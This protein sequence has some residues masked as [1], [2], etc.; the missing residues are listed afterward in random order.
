M[1]RALVTLGGAALAALAGA[2]L[3]LFGG[4]ILGRALFGGLDGAL[5]T[6]ISLWA[7]PRI[8]HSRAQQEGA[9]QAAA[10]ATAAEVRERQELADRQ[11]SRR[12]D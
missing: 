2:V 11:Q 12:P 3:G 4:N 1:K 9:R 7:G 10:R 8:E 5:I 6:S